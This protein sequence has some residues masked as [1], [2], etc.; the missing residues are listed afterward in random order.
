MGLNKTPSPFPIATTTC[1]QIFFE[2]RFL[3]VRP[4]IYHSNLSFLKQLLFDILFIKKEGTIP[5]EINYYYYFGNDYTNFIM[6]MGFC[7]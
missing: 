3:F 4:M 1:C 5:S 6:C 2:Q 7:V